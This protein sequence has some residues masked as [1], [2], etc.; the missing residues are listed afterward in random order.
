MLEDSQ[1]KRILFEDGVSLVDTSVYTKMILKGDEIPSS[2]KVVCGRDA[3]KYKTVFGE[4]VVFD[5]STVR[6]LQPPDH[7][8]DDDSMDTLMSLLKSSP[9]M[10]NT[11]EYLIRLV[12]ELEFFERT[13]N[14]KFL[15]AVNGMFKQ[16]KET[17]VVWGVGRGSACASL[18]LFILEVHD[19][20]PITFDIRFSELSKDIEDD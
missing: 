6:E 19:V 18:V 5:E 11:D 9:R 17:G 8:S 7:T 14:I 4:D 15:L 20:N 1:N 2:V 12:K 3:D 13:G 10:Q 16:F